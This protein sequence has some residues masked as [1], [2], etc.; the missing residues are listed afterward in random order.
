MY[1]VGNATLR[2]MIEFHSLIFRQQKKNEEEE[3]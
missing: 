1:S 3:E 2:T